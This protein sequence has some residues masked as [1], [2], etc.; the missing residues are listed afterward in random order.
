MAGPLVEEVSGT[1]PDPAAAR[2]ARVRWAACWITF[3]ILSFSTV[4]WRGRLTDLAGEL[5]L[6]ALITFAFHFPATHHL[7]SRHTIAYGVLQVVVASGLGY[8]IF[9]GSVHLVGNQSSF[10]GVFLAFFFGLTAGA[11]GTVFAALY[12]VLA[13][14][15][16][17]LYLLGNRLSAVDSYIPP[18]VLVVLLL[19]GVAGQLG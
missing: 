8:L 1:T 7:G 19:R 17:L 10:A 15:S 16:T 11:F 3:G 2:I 9:W 12:A 6:V 13:L 5:L 4:T 14:L 18:L